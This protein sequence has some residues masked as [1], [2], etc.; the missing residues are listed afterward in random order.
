MKIIKIVLIAS[1]LI[2][3]TGCK[4]KYVSVPKQE[5][6]TSL[7]FTKYQQKGFLIT[8]GTYG[9]NYESLGMFSFTVYPESSYFYKKDM[10]NKHIQKRM[11]KWHQGVVL[12]QEVLDL[13]YATAI[14]KGADAITHFNITNPIKILNDGERDFT[15]EGLKINGLLIKRKITK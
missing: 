8:P 9:E 13:A 12:S 10:N 5:V 14:K 15:I 11:K 2:G 4:Q 3:I 1:V 6:I 7:D